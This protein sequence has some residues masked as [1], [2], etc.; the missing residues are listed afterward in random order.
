MS[1][2]VR[3]V[4]RFYRERRIGRRASAVRDLILHFN[5][6][7]RDAGCLHGPLRTEAEQ[8]FRDLER[9]GL[10][11]LECASRDFSAILHVRVPPASEASFF[12]HVGE[13]APNAERHQLADLFEKAA[14]SPVPEELAEGWRVFCQECA[15]IARSGE[16]LAPCFDRRSLEQTAQILDALPRLLAWKS[17][18]FLRFASAAL[19]GNSK[20]LEEKLQSK[21]EACLHR[22][23]AGRLQT[24]ADL[25]IRENPRGVILHGPLQITLPDRTLDL[26]GLRLPVQIS[27]ADLQAANLRT[28][29]TRCVTV[30]NAAMLHELAKFQSG[31]LLA[32]SG[33]KGGFAHSA[34]L[35]FLRALPGTLE[36][37]HF[38]DSDPAG[39]D[40][41]RHLRERTQL[42]I[43]ALHM[44]YRPS[45]VPVLLSKEDVKILLRALDSPYLGEDEKNTL[46]EM[47]RLNDKGAFEQESLGLPVSRWPFYVRG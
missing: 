30:E 14:E 29:A 34:I 7:L 32:S 39:F 43:T 12:A 15:Q 31:I 16:G 45:A 25:G 41:L 19:F 8:E 1:P 13:V 28:T 38:G 24:L 23:S 40:I 4:A 33:S 44:S 5:N 3:L 10:V 36:F 26:G 47:E 22:I 21:I 18:S 17:E 9:R 42:S 27:A 2:A 35:D 6:L 11:K 46:R 20:T 37:F